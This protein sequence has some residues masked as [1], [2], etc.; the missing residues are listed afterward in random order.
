RLPVVAPWTA[1]RSPVLHFAPPYAPTP[2]RSTLVP[3]PRTP[4][5]AHRGVN[6]WGA[7]WAAGPPDNPARPAETRVEDPSRAGGASEA[8]RGSAGSAVPVRWTRSAVRRPHR[9]GAGRAATAGETR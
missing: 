6:V 8:R 5:R 2:H 4:R 7:A 9:T 1:D 3:P